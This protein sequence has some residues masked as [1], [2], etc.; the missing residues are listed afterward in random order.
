MLQGGLLGAKK[1]CPS[2]RISGPIG[3][4]PSA[5]DGTDDASEA[6]SMTRPEQNKRNAMAFYDLMLNQTRPA[7]AIDR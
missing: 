6:L 7:Q 2:R 1:R 3:F 5:P 4:E